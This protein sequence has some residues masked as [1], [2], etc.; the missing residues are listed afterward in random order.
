M[1]NSALYLDSLRR[2]VVMARGCTEPA[3][4]ALCAAAAAR[5]LGEP[6][7]SAALSVSSY[8]YKNGMNV[9]IPGVPNETGIAI[10]AALGCVVADPERGLSVMQQLSADEIRRARRMVD[11]GNVTVSIQPTSEKVYF[12]AECRSQNHASRCVIAG[13]HDRIL[14]KELD[15]RIVY[16]A[17]D[18]E[19][20]DQADKNGGTEAMTV[21]GI[22][23]FCRTAPVESL[24]MLREVAAVNSRIA[25]EG[26][27][28]EWGLRIGKTLAAARRSG[29]YHSGAAQEAIALT[30]A[31][32][33][34]RMAGCDLPVMSTAGSGNQGLTASLPIIAA[35]KHASASEETTLRA[36]AIS[37]LIT[38]HTKTYLGRLSAL[39][40]CGVSAAIGVCAGLVFM[41]DGGDDAV[42]AAMR[43]MA[44]DITG[45]FCDGAKPG[46]ALKIATCVH[47]AY[48]AAAL[49]LAGVGANARDGIVRM[50]IEETLAGIGRLGSDAMSSVNDAILSLLKEA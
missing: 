28:G 3:A 49:A 38:I 32:A 31:A 1:N 23:D 22:L 18:D 40:G 34:A 4:A 48:Q 44:A 50:D 33:D 14:L 35:A 7:R 46:C 9:G 5:T 39:C 26:L 17:S 16:R 29:F 27:R 20:G 12:Q 30:A 24:L 15:G 37:L 11:D 2:E 41:M 45:M 13:Y 10:A 21:R 43:S 19:R 25:Q 36:L 8:V 47:A 42:Y 6:V